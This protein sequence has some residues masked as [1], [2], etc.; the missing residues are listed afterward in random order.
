MI[1]D[2]LAAIA[3]YTENNKFD[4]G[5]SVAEC[6]TAITTKNTNGLLTTK[7]ETLTIPGGTKTVSDSDKYK[8]ILHGMLHRTPLQTLNSDIANYA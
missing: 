2:T 7:E 5:A 8:H 4:S 1:L 6:K 3:D